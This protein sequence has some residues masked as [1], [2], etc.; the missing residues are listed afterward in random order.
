MPR[1]RRTDCSS[2]CSHLTVAPRPDGPRTVIRAHADMVRGGGGAISAAG[3]LD[4]DQVAFAD[5]PALW[6]EG[7]GGNGARP[8]IIENITGGIARNG[9][10]E[11]SIAAPAGPFRRH[12]RESRGRHRRRTT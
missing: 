4:L 9:H 7:V 11:V 12:H 3:R 10:I 1:A 5:L 2:H 6:P 8:W